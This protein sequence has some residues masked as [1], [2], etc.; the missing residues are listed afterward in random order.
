M[1]IHDNEEFCLESLYDNA[2]DD[3][4]ILLDD[5]N[6]NDIENGIGEVL[7]LAIRSP[8][9]FESDQSYCYDIITSGFEEVMTLV[10]F[11]QLFWSL[12]NITCL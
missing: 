6:Y 2:L 11:D 4:P 5:I 12:I 10:N 3:G 9:P 1:G 8:I 7:T